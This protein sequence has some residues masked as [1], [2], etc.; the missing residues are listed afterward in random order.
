MRVVLDTNVW[1]D[2]LLFDDPAV[3]PLRAACDA[4]TVEVL[5]DAPCEAE[6]ERVLGY[7]FY[8]ETLSPEKQAACLDECRRVAKKVEADGRN[9]GRLP[10]CRDPDDQKFLELA[11]AARA[12]A[13]VTKDDALLALADRGLAFRIVKPAMVCAPRA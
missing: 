5:I 6:L 3:A 10:V 7:R 12:D 11:A 8:G 2:W 1:L 9:V 4:G 13:L